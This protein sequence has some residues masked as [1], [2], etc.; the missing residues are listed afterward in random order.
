MAR[1]PTPIVCV[2]IGEGGSGGA[3]GIGVGDRIAMLEHA[4][5]SVISPEGCGTILWKASDQAPKAAAALRLTSR[6]L[7][8][9]GVIDEVI[10]EP[11]G[12]AHRSHLEAGAAVKSFLSRALRDLTDLPRTEL[13]ERR[14]AKFRRIG[15]FVEGSPPQNGQPDAAG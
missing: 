6:D 14:Y 8:R 2:V 4:Y 7:L 5:Y 1:L 9:M 12:G 3:L 13:L 11:L 10:P 15:D